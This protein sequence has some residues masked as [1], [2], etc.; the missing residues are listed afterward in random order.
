[1]HKRYSLL[2]TALLLRAV[3]LANIAQPGL[4]IAGGNGMFKPFFPED[5]SAVGRIRMAREAVFIQA[6]PGFAVVKGR[7]W[8]VNEG[9]APVRMKT[10]YPL[11][12]AEGSSDIGGLALDYRFDSLAA[13]R[14]VVGG[15]PVSVTLGSPDPDFGRWYVWDMQFAPHDTTLIEVYFIVNTNDA[16]VRQG[17]RHK[18]PNAFVYVLETGASWQ[19]PIGEGLLCLQWM[20]GLDWD[21]V[22]G[23]WP[24]SVY[25]VDEKRRLIVRR[26]R[27]LTPEP[28]DNLVVTYGRPLNRVDFKAIIEG[29][30]GLYAAIDGLA[31]SDPS[32]WQLSGRRFDSPFEVGGMGISWLG[33]SLIGM[34]ILPILLLFAGVWLWRK[35]RKGAS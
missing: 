5:S 26:F 23:L 7:Y 19:H 1:M 4:Y 6:Y 21:D 29:S 31:G 35:W 9:A 27:D 14:V 25:Q 18:E 24:D 2:L 28:A 20:D 11:W 15:R 33:V 13:L 34:V 8:M 30:A 10:G 22:D 12:P 32:E 16:M 17:Y 3:L